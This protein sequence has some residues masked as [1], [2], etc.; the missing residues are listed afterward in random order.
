MHTAGAAGGQPGLAA[1]RTHAPLSALYWP[2]TPKKGRA[3]A[4]AAVAAGTLPLRETPPPTPYSDNTSALPWRW[5]R[6]VRLGPNCASSMSNWRMAPCRRGRL[7][8]RG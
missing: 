5:M 8:G 1:A 2:N 6:S 3:A 4:S 7:K